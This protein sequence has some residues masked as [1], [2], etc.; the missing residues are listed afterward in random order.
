MEFIWNLEFGIWHFFIGGFMMKIFL[1]L[2][3]FILVV[4]CEKVKEPGAQNTAMP[5]APLTGDT[6]AQAPTQGQAIV[7]TPS[8][9]VANVVLQP[10]AAAS[11][12]YTVEVA[13]TMDEKRTGLMHRENLPDNHGMWFIF[14]EDVQDPFWMKDTPL[15]L[16]LIF[17]DKDYK[18]VDIIANATPNSELLL[19]PH[20]KY[21]YVLEA[22]AGAA[23]LAKLAVGDKL[24]YRLG[25][26]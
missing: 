12:I 19:V 15:A 22:K 16:D 6:V 8:I 17:V 18:V 20:Q 11:V 2:I 7:P 14:D 24:E 26:P 9:N 5:P 13:Q 1:S 10:K 25:P 23:A 4:G 21:R 3:C